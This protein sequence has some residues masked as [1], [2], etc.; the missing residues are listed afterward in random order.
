M[1][2]I[3]FTLMMVAL[4]STLSARTIQPIYFDDP[5]FDM[6]SS[7]L[8]E[9]QRS[10][11][12]RYITAMEKMEAGEDA[13]KFFIIEHAEGTKQVGPLL[14][15]IN[16]DQGTPYNNHC[17]IING[18]RAVTGCVATAMAEVMR[19]YKFPAKGTGTFT[20]TDGT[21]AEEFVLDDHPFDW[22]NMLETYKQGQYNDAQA[23][24][25]ANL[26]LAC[27]ASLNMNYSK[28]G[29]GANTERV[30]G[31]LKNN[32]GYDKKCAYISAGNGDVA[33]ENYWGEDV[34]RPEFDAGHPIIFA[35]F[36]SA[37]VSG[38]CFVLDGYK[39]IDGEYYYHVNWGWGGAGNGWCLLTSLKDFEGHDYSGYN[40]QMVYYIYPAGTGLEETED[41]AGRATKILRDGQLIIERNN[42]QYTVQGMRIQ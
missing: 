19:Y 12:D 17:P 26:M 30:E 7:S 40:V 14:G 29:S 37:G 22:P 20:Y 6:R 28:D 24:A 41:E 25:I 35:G 15:N 9:E 11:F 2:K 13:E 10:F 16:Y 39:T 23:N 32:F 5:T 34:L 4:M 21:G 1:K 38:H 36:P 8:S 33:E 18:G 3:S 27:G 42:R 31:L